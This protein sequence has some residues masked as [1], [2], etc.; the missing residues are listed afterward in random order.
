MLIDS[1]E[2]LEAAVDESESATVCEV[3]ETVES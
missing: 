3:A 2:E 1:F